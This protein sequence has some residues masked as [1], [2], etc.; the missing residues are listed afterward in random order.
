[1]SNE[2]P[3]NLSDDHDHH[4][5]ISGGQWESLSQNGQDDEYDDELDDVYTGDEEDGNAYD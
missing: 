5:V 2:E 3:S 4:T 1:M